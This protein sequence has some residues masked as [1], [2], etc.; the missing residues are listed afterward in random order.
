VDASNHEDEDIE[1][2]DEYEDGADTRVG[3][4][5][6]NAMPSKGGLAHKKPKAAT[7]R[8]GR[9]IAVLSWL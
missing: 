1:K 5:K 8:R 2:S 4:K 3:G 6:R 9:M 7:A